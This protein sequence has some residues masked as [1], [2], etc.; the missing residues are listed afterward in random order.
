M[1]TLAIDIGGT[2]I[3]A[4]LVDTDQVR[5]VHAV[6]T[7]ASEG[8]DRVLGQIQDVIDHYSG[9]SSIA[10]ASAGV[11]KDG[12]VIS[13]TNTL[14]GWA[15]T[16]LAGVISARTS[17]PVSVVG[18]VHAHG[19][20]EAT[21]GA[22]RDYESCLTVAVGT[23]IGGAMVDHG[24]L[25]VGSLGVAGHIG[26]VSSGGAVGLPCS[27]GRTGH[28][29]AI[30]SGYGVTAAYRDATGETLGGREIDERAEAG[31]EAAQRILHG[32]AYALGEILGSSANMLNPAVMVLS[33]SMTR[34]GPGWW[35]AL[36]AGF[37]ESAMDIVASTPIVAGT[38]GDYAPL[39]GATVYGKKEEQ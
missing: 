7:P 31:D 21:Y 39:I 24:F 36:R 22:G 8:A 29:E 20:G 28:I 17:V 30:A 18:D 27:C 25:Q 6:P 11:I 3:R 14:P 5:D 34:S 9:F 38:L 35:A 37:T 15:G 12:R 26:H 33:G 13:A 16:D 19:L 4:G 10:I 23:G 2:K 1:T 32:S